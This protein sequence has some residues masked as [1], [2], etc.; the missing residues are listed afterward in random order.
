MNLL[1]KEQSEKNIL[2][3][4]YQNTDRYKEYLPQYKEQADDLSKI[5][6]DNLYF[7]LF[8]YFIYYCL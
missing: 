3:V 8:F 2:A 7:N 5:T 1:R 4:N 6:F